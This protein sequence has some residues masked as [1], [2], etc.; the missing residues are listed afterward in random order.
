MRTLESRPAPDLGTDT[1]A[2][3]PDS[4][5][6][7]ERPDNH[8]D[9]E[10]E[11]LKFERLQMISE[12]RQIEAQWKR[13]APLL[14]HDIGAP[15]TR[16]L[17]LTGTLLPNQS[18]PDL[19]QL[20]Q[21]ARNHPRM[22]ALRDR[23]EMAR[24]RDTAGAWPQEISVAA[25]FRSSYAQDNFVPGY[26]AGVSLGLPLWS[27]LSDGPSVERATFQKRR[28]AWRRHVEQKTAT[29]VGLRGQ[30]QQLQQA[31]RQFRRQTNIPLDD[32]ST[33]SESGSPET[34]ASLQQAQRKLE[35]RLQW[36]A[37]ALQTRSAYIALRGAAGN[38]HP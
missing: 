15:P 3:N 18:S 30:F 35:T 28:A 16:S 7:P 31:C 21:L 26:F 22:K 19:D 5:R 20:D 29:L 17:E 37:L 9:T 8:T 6:P 24:K 34:T 12:H 32:A 23:A 13:L 36:I 25:G 2:Q 10:L 38:S 1:A 33:G 11:A 27:A 14:L 4:A